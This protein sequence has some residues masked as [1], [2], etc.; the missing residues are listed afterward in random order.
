LGLCGEVWGFSVAEFAF[1][2]ACCCF[3][4]VSVYIPL[5]FLFGLPGLFVR[6]VSL[7]ISQGGN[8]NISV[9][10]ACHLVACILHNPNL[11]T[12]Y[13]DHAPSACVAHNAWRSEGLPVLSAGV[14]AT[15]WTAVLKSLRE[16]SMQNVF[17]EVTPD[18]V[19]S[20]FLCCLFLHLPLALPGRS[21]QT[22]APDVRRACCHTGLQ[23][24]VGPSAC[25]VCCLKR[26]RQ[27]C[28]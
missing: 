26:R 19:G 5:I 23:C 1:G 12:L 25:A 28:R 18:A 2:C 8:K 3:D 27:A 11:T 24:A 10:V 6:C 14:V 7:R 21:Q 22:R 4:F 15:E 20:S 16:V 17:F 13:L 9:A